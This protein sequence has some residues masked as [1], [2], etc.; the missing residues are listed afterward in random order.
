MDHHS[1]SRALI[2]IVF[3]LNLYK[4]TEWCKQAGAIY[5]GYLSLYAWS[6]GSLRI[7]GA[8][9][10]ALLKSD[11]P[12]TNNRNFKSVWLIMCKCRAWRWSE[13]YWQ[14]EFELNMISSCDRTL[15]C[16]T[17]SRACSSSLSMSTRCWTD[18]TLWMSSSSARINLQ[19]YRSP[20]PSVPTLGC[21]Q[22]H[23]KQQ[24]KMVSYPLMWNPRFMPNGMEWIQTLVMEYWHMSGTGSHDKWKVY[25][26]CCWSN[27]FSS[28]SFFTSSCNTPT[29]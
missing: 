28:V 29:S 22:L 27:S 11:P 6:G 1:F 8:V 16:R 2:F 25:L 19:I 26:A 17:L 7:T 12:E 9:D 5:A 13:H 18:V 10:S 23:W 15:R 14:L 3:K 21:L 20:L 24:P 4:S